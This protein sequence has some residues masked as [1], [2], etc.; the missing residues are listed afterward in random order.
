MERLVAAMFHRIAFMGLCAAA[1][2]LVLIQKAPAADN[3]M[4][5][6]DVAFMHEA[7]SGGMAEVA[8]GR[9]A[10][11][12]GASQDVKNFGQKMVDDHSKA[13]AALRKMAEGKGV[14]LP[15]SLNKEDQE[16]VDRLEKLSGSD[17]DKAYAKEMVA[18]HAKDISAFEKA[19]K[20]SNDKDV[21]AWANDT[22]GT[23]KE[24]YE[25]AKTLASKV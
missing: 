21:R 6:G 19:S 20:E 7:A 8:L 2:A 11:E 16:M 24:H 13:D 25:L 14:N 1:A 10:V 18:D 22:L 12:H 3:V 23:I 9:Y 5:P 17:F 15:M 4:T